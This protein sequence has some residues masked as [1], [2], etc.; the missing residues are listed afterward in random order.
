[1]TVLASYTTNLGNVAWC[2]ATTA[3]AYALFA[4][5][6]AAEYGIMPVVS[7]RKVEA[8]AQKRNDGD[9]ALAKI[10]GSLTHAQRS[11]LFTFFYDRAKN[12][13]VPS[14]VIGT[15]S[16]GTVA[17]LLPARDGFL[18]ARNAAI[19]GAISFAAAIP[20][21]LRLLMPTNKVLISVMKGDTVKESYVP[22]LLERWNRAHLVRIVLFAIS[23]GSAL[24]L[25]ESLGEL[26]LARP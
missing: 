20:V 9:E 19:L 26:R 22:K 1:M 25:R 4:N 10:S 24:I 13:I 17:Y 15:L 11:Q 14:I 2:L 12:R 8:Q 18:Q 21:T 23:F 5:L 3:S 6:G 16:F 7:Q